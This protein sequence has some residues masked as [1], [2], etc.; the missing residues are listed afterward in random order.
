MFAAD[1]NKSS[2][3]WYL[4]LIL[5]IHRVA[6][7]LIRFSNGSVLAGDNAIRGS[8]NNNV[9]GNDTAN[10]NAGVGPG[11]GLG[12]DA[13][14][15]GLGGGLG[16][17]DDDAD[18]GA[19][20]GGLGG[21]DDDDDS[22]DYDDQ[23][24]MIDDDDEAMGDN[25]VPGV[26]TWV[27]K[28]L[29]AL[30]V[31]VAMLVNAG[32]IDEHSVLDY[33]P[34]R[35][36]RD[37]PALSNAGTIDEHLILDFC[38]IRNNQDYPA[39]SATSLTNYQA[40][41]AGTIDEHPI[42]D[43]CP[44][45][46]D[47]NYLVFNPATVDDAWHNPASDKI[48]TLSSTSRTNYKKSMARG[49]DEHPIFD[50]CPIRDDR[51]YLVTNPA[52]V[53]DA[54]HDPASDKIPTLSSTSATNYKKSMAEPIDLVFDPASADDAST[55]STSSGKE[56]CMAIVLFR[57]RK[58]KHRVILRDS[59]YWNCSP[60]RPLGIVYNRPYPTDLVD[61][62]H[63]PAPDKF[64]ALSSTSRTYYQ[65]SMAEPIDEHPFL[66]Y[67]GYPIPDYLVVAIMAAVVVM[68]VVFKRD[69]ADR[70][71]LK[72]ELADRLDTFETRI[73]VS[74]VRLDMVETR[75]EDSAVRLDTVETRTEDS[76]VRLDRN[77]RR[78]QS[79][80]RKFRQE[81]HSKYSFYIA[82][83][84]TLVRLSDENGNNLILPSTAA[85]AVIE[86]EAV[87]VE[88][89][90]QQQNQSSVNNARP[91]TIAT[92]T[93]KTTGATMAATTTA[94][95]GGEQQQQFLQQNQ[96]SV[97]NPKKR[98][99]GVW[100]RVTKWHKTQKRKSSHIRNDHGEMA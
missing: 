50:Y 62:L 92:A 11:V 66:D 63:D 91:T 94:T 37:Y 67:R 23:F 85:A 33:C 35:R 46:D 73:E 15:A 21:G 17:G 56:P 51:N 71:A 90:Q 75:T 32:T 7:F 57:R 98:K 41:M 24:N 45:R 19:G 60:P 34:I 96:A 36:N 86:E 82:I 70:L 2:A 8:S 61:A 48:P 1:R 47:R 80:L 20:G 78:L 69:R 64:A 10:G 28:V 14:G 40:S 13:T 65:K 5:F 3:K 31:V 83:S 89:Q 27:P 58:K 25:T 44:I 76:A 100:E 95:A 12:G 39:L 88:Q 55:G 74:T 30:A 16:G 87:G 59:G 81:R 29:V 42:F 43:Y 84:K 68:F 38:P 97:D 93:A 72:K 9:D 49:I 18:D 6:F 53:D 52:S 79:L 54:W 77:T 22:G 99:R 4:I 26:G